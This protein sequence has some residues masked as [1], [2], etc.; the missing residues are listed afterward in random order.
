VNSHREKRILRGS[1]G[2]EGS[3]RVSDEL[4]AR[5]SVTAKLEEAGIPYMITGSMAA[6]FYAIPRMTR[7]IDLAIELSERDVD[8]VARLFQPEYNIQED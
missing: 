5:Q 1:D 8:R 7:N 3:P 4:E 6:N 2:N